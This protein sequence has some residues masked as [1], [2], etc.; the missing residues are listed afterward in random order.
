MNCWGIR[1][2]FT[3]SR[4]SL[5]GGYIVYI[6]LLSGHEKII[7]K[8]G[9]SLNVGTLNRG[10]TVRGLYSLESTDQ[11]LSEL[12]VPLF[13]GTNGQVTLRGYKEVCWW[14][15]HNTSIDLWSFHGTCF[16]GLSTTPWI[17]VL[18][19]KLLIRSPSPFIETQIE[20]FVQVK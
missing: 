15:K 9:I 1:I 18:L 12:P 13:V 10:F 6:E 3:K 16:C 11:L 14:V 20:G 19:E 17:T 2:Y 4:F 5:S 7:T 8:S